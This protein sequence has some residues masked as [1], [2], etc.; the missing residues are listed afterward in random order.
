VSL[1]SLLL[2]RRARGSSAPHEDGASIALVVEGGAMRGVISAG[3]VSALGDLGYLRAFDAVYGSSAGA[4]NAAYF[5]AGQAGLGTTIYYEDINNRAFI[6]LRRAAA[7]RPIVD[8]AY[9][10]DDV[11]IHRKRLDV[12]RVLSSPTP[13]SVLA[14]DL[15]TRASRVLGPF[16]DAVRLFGALRASATMPVVAGGP[17]VHEQRRYLDASLSEPIPVPTAEARGHTHVLALLTRSGAMRPHP[18]AFDRYFVGPRLRRISPALATQYLDRAGPYSALLRAIDA[19]RGP[20]GRAEVVGLRVEGLRV[21]KLECRAAILK[22][23][24]AS[25]YRTVLDWITN[26]GPHDP[27]AVDA[28]SGA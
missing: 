14:T 6:S 27:S 28:A 25:G 20:L 10:L 11:V 4:I 26:P 18:S 9:L 23:A 22:A 21:S 5:L 3:M 8:L 15:D 12:D 24:A 2:A 16:D 7:G 13:L 19:G 17:F 1:R